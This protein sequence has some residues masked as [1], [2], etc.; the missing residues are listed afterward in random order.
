MSFS[1]KVKSE[2]FNHMGKDRHCQ[3]AELSAF[4]T[5]CATVK[6]D[7]KGHFLKFS[8]ENVLL[9]KKCLLLLKELFKIDGEV[10][11]KNNVGL[12]KNKN[13][14]I[15]IFG[16][17]ETN[18]LFSATGDFSKSISSLIVKNICCKRAYIR[19]AFLSVGSISNPEKTY[20]LEFVCADYAYACQLKDLINFFELDAKIVERK[21]HFI[22]YLKEGEQIVD[23]LNIIGA[24]VSLLGLENV[25]VVKD[26]RNNVN[27]IVNCETAN[28]NK[29]IKASVKHIDD[30]HYINEKVG[31]NSLP[32]QLID[33][34]EKRV[35]FPEASLKELG[36]MLT[37]T[38]GKSGVNHRLRKISDI[39][40]FLKGGQL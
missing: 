35:M 3:I 16:G 26:M 31:I 14:V 23:M 39:A 13:C 30:I 11:F 6:K 38:V 21:N 18:K 33:I 28:L 24:H 37:P 22:L 12:N 36:D 27:R 20:H 25:R 4:V 10:I 29:T 40:Q 19:G 17:E 1:T 8:F 34:A 32:E 15:I 9:A 7:E 5:L 2:I